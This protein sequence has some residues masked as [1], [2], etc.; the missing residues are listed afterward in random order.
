MEIRAFQ[1]T[2]LYALSLQNAQMGL[3]D[4]IRGEGYGDSLAAG[5][6]AFTVTSR[7][8]IV[9]CVGVIPQWENYSRAWALLSGDSGRHLLGITRAI[10][11]WL[12]FH[13]SGRV[14]TSVVVDFQQAIRW[15]AMLGF[16]REGLMRKYTPDGKDCYLY[17]Q[18]V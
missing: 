13:N 12:R 8:D 16:V 14:D 6:P 17:A 18:V 1:P 7:G 2:D 3:H 10:R 9:A 5:G 15:A 4:I 11:R